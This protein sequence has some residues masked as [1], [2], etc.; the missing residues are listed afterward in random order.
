MV[1]HT[2][3][4]VFELT[5]PGTIFGP[6]L[7]PLKSYEWAS[8]VSRCG[9][10]FVPACLLNIDKPSHRVPLIWGSHFVLSQN[11]SCDANHFFFFSIF[12]VQ[13]CV[14]RGKAIFSA[15][16]P[17]YVSLIIKGFGCCRSFRL[18][19]CGSLW[20]RRHL[21]NQVWAFGWCCF[22][23]SGTSTI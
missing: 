3:V 14:S 5:R 2:I 16:W 4:L 15:V 20:W 1:H 21:T 17:C 7:G 10:V 23:G 9:L 8:R 6:C 12:E 19:H 11:A 22:P 13:F 18:K